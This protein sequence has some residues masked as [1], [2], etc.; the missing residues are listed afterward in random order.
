VLGDDFSERI[1]HVIRGFA[2]HYSSKRRPEDGVLK[3]PKH[4][5]L[6][7]TNKTDLCG[8]CNCVKC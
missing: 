4:V 2:V 3:M 5:F 6:L 1:N 7:D 8:D